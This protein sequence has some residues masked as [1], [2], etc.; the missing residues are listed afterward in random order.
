[1]MR[2]KVVMVCLSTASGLTAAL[3]RDAAA[4]PWA[5]AIVDYS[6]GTTAQPGYTMPSVALGSPE[7]VT[8]EI[9]GFPRH[10]SMFHPP[11]G[12]DEIVSIGEGGHLTIHMGQPVTNDPAH[13]YGVDLIVFGKAAFQDADYPNGQQ[14]NPARLFG[15]QPL[16]VE[17]SADGTSWFPVAPRANSL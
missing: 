3:A 5:D 6:P 10:V 7:R 8:G 15:S 11:F 14:Y 2:M 17:V 13:L 12:D 4:A 9:F 16:N 1:K